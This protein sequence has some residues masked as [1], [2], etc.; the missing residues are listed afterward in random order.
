MSDHADDPTPDRTHGPTADR[1]DD[2]IL[3]VERL[4][5]AY[6]SETVLDLLDL[7]V[8]R[9][10]VLGVVGESST[11]K[12]T[13]ATALVDGVPAPGSISGTITY[14]PDEGDPV[15]VLEL[16]DDALRRFRRETV[17]LVSGDVGGFEPTAPLRSQ[18]RPVLRATDADEERLRDLLA[19]VGLDPERVLDTRPDELSAG[20]EQLAQVVRGVLADPAVLVLDDLPLAFDR[21]ARGDL[22]EVLG[23][24]ASAESD[25]DGGTTVV[26]LGSDLPA[27]ASMADRLAM[28]HDGHV[29]E[30]GPTDRLLDEPEHPHTRTLVDFYRGP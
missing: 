13:L 16:D 19:A 24:D 30:S 12:T 22:S 4:S 17:A 27:L 5:A 21:L 23:T 28:L 8:P 29:V 15:R 9:G 20:T 26:V 1:V 25:R 18:F 14:R 11:G 7:S 2:P 3:D 10:E 6:G